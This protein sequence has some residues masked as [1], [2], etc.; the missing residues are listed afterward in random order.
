MT[1]SKLPVPS[2]LA[3]FVIL[4]NLSRIMLAVCAVP[5]DCAPFAPTGAAAL[6]PGLSSPSSLPV[7][8][9]PPLS[10]MD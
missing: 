4:I 1:A 8:T 6:A 2:M 3:E 10:V 9:G 5:S 7:G